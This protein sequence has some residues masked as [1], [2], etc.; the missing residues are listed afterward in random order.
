[1]SQNI[2]GQFFKM[3]TLYL[4]SVK[5]NVELQQLVFLYCKL[6]P[7][8]LVFKLHLGVLVVTQQK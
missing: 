5:N 7:A 3:K 8:F 2:I 6:S 4:R 1:M